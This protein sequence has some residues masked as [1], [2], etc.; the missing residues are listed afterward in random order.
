MHSRDVA[1]RRVGALTHGTCA[2]LMETKC[3]TWQVLATAGTP[4]RQRSR[5]RTFFAGLDTFE[6]L[7]DEQRHD[8]AD[9]E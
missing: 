9:L 8:P 1:G 5:D 2:A 3:G 7:S 6:S 4:P